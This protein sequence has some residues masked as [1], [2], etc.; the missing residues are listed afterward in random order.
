V[1]N[2]TPI[3]GPINFSNLD[4]PRLGRK[5]RCIG[6]L[7]QNGIL[8]LGHDVSVSGDVGLDENVPMSVPHVREAVLVSD[9]LVF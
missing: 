8:S 7:F 2:A 3:R 1:V 5:A 4:G 9:E 6:S